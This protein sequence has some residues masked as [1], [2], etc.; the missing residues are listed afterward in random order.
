MHNSRNTEEIF[1][2]NVQIGAPDVCWEWLGDIGS[3][4]CGRMYYAGKRMGAHRIA[5]ILTYGDIPTY[6]P[7][8]PTVVIHACSNKSCCNP[9]HLMLGTRAD[10]KTFKPYSTPEMFWSK[11]NVVAATECWNWTGGTSHH[12]Y[13]SLGYHKKQVQAHRLAYELTYGYLPEYIN[14]EAIVVR[15]LCDNK[16]CCNPAHLAIGTHEDN[17]LDMRTSRMHPTAKLLP[18]QV[19]EI[20]QLLADGNKTH[21]EIGQ[22]FGVS[23]SN[24]TMIATSRIWR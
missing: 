22:M 6:D 19:D 11:V 23:S 16:L 20:K 14:G 9:N 12:Q 4:G 7:Y 1:W 18:S 15:H 8:K 10:H 17:M 2:T 13:G 3:A 24:I 5:W 21:K